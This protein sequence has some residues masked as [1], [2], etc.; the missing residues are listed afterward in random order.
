MNRSIYRRL[1]DVWQLFPVGI[2][3]RLRSSP[4]TKWLV[5]GVSKL[6]IKSASHQEIYDDAYYSYVDDTAGSSA[7]VMVTTLIEAFRPQK[8]IDVG[9]GSGA[10]I[11]KLNQLGVSAVGLEYSEKGI[12]ICRGKGLTVYAYNLESDLPLPLQEREFSM[13]CSFEVAEHL[14]SALADRFVEIL[15]SLSDKIVITAATVGQGG[16]DHVNE[17]PHS[18]WIE[19]FDQRYY[20]YNNELSLILREKWKAGGAAQWYFNNVMVFEYQK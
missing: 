18:Y 10:F 2:R 17:Q 6:T 14:P 7:S 1:K 3:N 13:A 15:C 4:L 20:R 8:V 12:E 19:K 5:K 9:C 16:L 11:A